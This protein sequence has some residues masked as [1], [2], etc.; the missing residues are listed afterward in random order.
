VEQVSLP[1]TLWDK[2]LDL[3]A[4]QFLASVSEQC[5][6]LRV[7]KH[8]FAG[9]LDDHHRVWSRLEKVAKWL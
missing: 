2:A 4:K 1:K 9:L 7:N 3:A 5:F 6:R 8:N